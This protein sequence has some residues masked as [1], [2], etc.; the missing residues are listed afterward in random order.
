[1]GPIT[2]IISCEPFRTIAGFPIPGQAIFSENA[3]AEGV[4]GPGGLRSEDTL[5]KQGAATMPA[6]VE[7][8]RQDS[9]SITISVCSGFKGN[10]TSRGTGR[11]SL[12]TL[13]KKRLD[14]PDVDFCTEGQN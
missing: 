11:P 5:G 3:I 6:C 10:A 1:M 13:R 14:R 7:T 4:E 9:K 2:R 8:S 12:I